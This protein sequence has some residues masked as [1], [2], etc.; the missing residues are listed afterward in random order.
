MAG[1][2]LGEPGGEVCTYALEVDGRGQAKGP[3]AL[4]GQRRERRTPILGV[5][6]PGDEPVVAQLVDDPADPGAAEN[7]GFPKILHPHPVV[8]SCGELEED[9]VPAEGQAGSS[10]QLSIEDGD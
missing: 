6:D 4:S 5:R 10:G 8:R 3:G 2:A 9:V 7:G 1:L